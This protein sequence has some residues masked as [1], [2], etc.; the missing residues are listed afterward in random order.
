MRL[1]KHQIRLI[2]NTVALHVGHSRKIFLFGSRLNDAA[3]GGDVDLLLEVD[4]PF[5][6]LEQARLVA[7]LEQVLD[8][9]VDIVVSQKGRSLP[10]FHKMIREQAVPLSGEIHEHISC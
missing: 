10:S 3:R 5:S 9:P 1:S 8:L 6:R 2:L 7:A 4:H